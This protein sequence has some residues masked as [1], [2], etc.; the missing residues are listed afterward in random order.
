MGA[1]ERARLGVH[2]L[3]ASLPAALD[4][5]EADEVLLAALGPL[6]SRSYLTVKRAEADAFAR[7]DVAQ[8]CF[9]HF[10]KY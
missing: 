3:P 10:T 2:R 1:A 6:R 7:A 4:A 8:E 5:L 9:H